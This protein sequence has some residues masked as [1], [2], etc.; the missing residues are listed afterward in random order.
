LRDFGLS[1]QRFQ[2]IFI[3]SSKRD[4][5]GEKQFGKTELSPRPKAKPQ[6]EKDKVKMALS[7]PLNYQQEAKVISLYGDM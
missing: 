2:G 4:F 7:A 6:R 5:F 1:P 3:I